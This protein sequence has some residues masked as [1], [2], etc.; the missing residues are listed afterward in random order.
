MCI[1]MGRNCCCISK[2]WLKGNMQHPQSGKISNILTDNKIKTNSQSICCP[3]QGVFL[4]KKCHSSSPT[5]RLRNGLSSTV[6]GHPK[7]WSDNNHKKALCS[8]WSNCVKKMPEQNI[9]TDKRFPFS[10]WKVISMYLF[11]FAVSI[12]CF[13]NSLNGDFVHDDIVAITTN[14]DV[15]GLTHWHEVF[16]HDYWGKPMDNPDSHK[17]YRPLTTLTFR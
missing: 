2:F 13:T 14:N 12:V 7:S 9:C 4:K 3:S 5:N 16:F 11:I 15:L 1:I 17:S 10:K 8:S 6:N